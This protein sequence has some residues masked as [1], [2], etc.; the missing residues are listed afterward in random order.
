[1]ANFCSSLAKVKSRGSER[2]SDSPRHS[3]ALQSPRVWKQS[4]PLLFNKKYNSSSES[5]W[6]SGCM[7]IS[8]RVRKSRSS[9][10]HCS[11]SLGQASRP[12]NREVTSAWVH[13]IH[14]AVRTFLWKFYSCTF[15]FKGRICSSRHI[16]LRGIH[17]PVPRHTSFCSKARKW[18]FILPYYM[19]W[20]HSPFALKLCKE[21]REAVKNYL[22]DFVQ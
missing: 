4:T 6:I 11:R 3:V 14:H 17:Y 5:M 22:A 15:I 2:R 1:M 10:C 16:S 19:H 7:Q 21:C 9:L 18:S 8:W 12:N 13:I 20:H